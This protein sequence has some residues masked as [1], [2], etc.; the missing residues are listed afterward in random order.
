MVGFFSQHLKKKKKKEKTILYDLP[1]D[2]SRGA[3]ELPGIYIYFTGDN[4][5]PE[6]SHSAVFAVV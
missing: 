1:K 3:L 4:S 2:L 6:Q 5:L